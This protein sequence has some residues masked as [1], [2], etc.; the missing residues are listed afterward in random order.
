MKKFFLK[1]LY[2][3]F[4]LGIAGLVGCQNPFEPIQKPSPQGKGR[5]VITVGDSATARTIAPTETIST[6]YILTFSGPA[7]VDQIEVTGASVEKEVELVVGDWTITATGYTGTAG[8]YV[9]IAEGSVATTVSEGATTP[10]SILLGPKT[11]GAVG[12]F[13]Y[14]LKIPNGLDSAQLFITT[15][16]GSN[17][18]TIP[19]GYSSTGINGNESLASGEYLA[20]IRL[21]KSSL[22]AGLTEALHIYSGLTS[23]LPLKEYT[24]TDFQA[25]V[26]AGFDLTSLV[27]APKS[28]AKPVTAFADQD[29]YTGTGA[30]QNN[31][32]ATVTGTFGENTV[33]KAVVTLEAKTG[34]TFT[35]IAAN[36]FTYTGATVANVADSG[37]VTITFPATAAAPAEP[38][39]NAQHLAM[40]Q[41]LGVNLTPDL[42]VAPNGQPY[43]PQS[44]SSTARAVTSGSGQSLGPLGKIYL[45]S[46]TEKTKTW[47]FRKLKTRS[48]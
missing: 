47:P 38:T 7:N 5:V 37:I 34:Y 26:G 24:D 16:E 48:K 6:R 28:W 33:Y 19:L 41:S 30:W 43:D 18:K 35:G 15:L 1:A 10:L 22:F 46:R 25:A 27:T 40:L 29:Q 11:G 39:S 42:P 36:S 23:T 45:C 17:V 31:A 8:N 14:S 21:E 4:V 9:A 12:T 3:G 13:S 44:S 20:R 2:L 32:N